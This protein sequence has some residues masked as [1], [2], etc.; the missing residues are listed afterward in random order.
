MQITSLRQEENKGMKNMLV[1][2]GRRRRKK[3]KIFQK[4]QQMS[5]CV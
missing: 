4:Q 3:A 5:V 2:T 1:L